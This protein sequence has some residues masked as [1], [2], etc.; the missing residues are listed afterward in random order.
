MSFTTI[1]CTLEIYDEET[2]A[3]EELR[4]EATFEVWGDEPET[5][6]RAGYALDYCEL[7]NGIPYEPSEAEEIML[8]AQFEKWRKD[9]RDDE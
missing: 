2:D 4:V 1:P 8:D 3:C 9:Q 7:E 6:T 5:G